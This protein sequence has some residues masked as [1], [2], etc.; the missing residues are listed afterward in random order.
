MSGGNSNSERA[1]T[2]QNSKTD[3]TTVDGV[4]GWLSFIVPCVQRKITKLNYD[5]IEECKRCKEDSTL[6]Q[7]I[8]DE[9]ERYVK[10]M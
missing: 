6:T 10:K 9:L 8:R 2:G 7:S 1:T 3:G 4:N 5:L